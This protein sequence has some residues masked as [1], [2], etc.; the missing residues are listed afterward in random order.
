MEIWSSKIGPVKYFRGVGVVCLLLPWA[1]R[2]PRYWPAAAVLT[3][4][5]IWVM[6]RWLRKNEATLRESSAMTELQKVRFFG[7]AVILVFGHAIALR[8]L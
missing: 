5:A 8:Y 4:G 2:I 7:Y 6:N 3:F 1:W